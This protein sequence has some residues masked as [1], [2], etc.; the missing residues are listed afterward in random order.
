[1]TTKRKLLA[2]RLKLKLKQVVDV[3]DVG[4]GLPVPEQ[5][6]VLVTRQSAECIA[7]VVAGH[8]DQ[9]AEDKYPLPL[10]GKSNLLVL[11]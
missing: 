8:A 1:M 6:V 10:K 11:I 3:V 2:C 4:G 9:V 7:A 5:V